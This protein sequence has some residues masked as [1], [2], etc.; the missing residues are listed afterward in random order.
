MLCI[1]RIKT[2]L[3]LL[4]KEFRIWDVILVSKISFMMDAR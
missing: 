2:V 4:V 1:Q 3:Y